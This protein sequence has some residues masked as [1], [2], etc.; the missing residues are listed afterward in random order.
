MSRTEML[1]VAT[2][3]RISGGVARGFEHVR[4]EFERN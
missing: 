1:D 3:P 4:V 2:R